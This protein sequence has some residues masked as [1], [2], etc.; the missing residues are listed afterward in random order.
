[1]LFWLILSVIVAF[2]FYVKKCNNYWKERGIVTVNTNFVFGTL[3]DFL[4]GRR[5][6]EQI[7]EDIYKTEPNE[8]YVGIYNMLKPVLLIRD[9]ELIHRIT[10]NDFSYFH[11]RQKTSTEGGRLIYSVAAL[12]GEEWK[13]VR[14]KLIPTFSTGKM[15]KMYD[16]IDEC[17]KMLVEQHLR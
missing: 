10:V 4:I 3:L 2:Y 13:T 16:L 7:H 11:D 12:G 9:P 6:I 15:R 14:N 1:M 8:P 17:A 5:S